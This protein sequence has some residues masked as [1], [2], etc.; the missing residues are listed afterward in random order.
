MKEPQG[1]P[2][3]LFVCAD[4]ELSIAEDFAQFGTDIAQLR[5]RLRAAQGRGRRRRSRSSRLSSGAGSAIENE[6][7][8]E[9]FHQTVSMKSVGNLTDFVRAH[10]LE[11]LD[12]AP[13]IEKLI[14]HFNDLNRAHEAVLKAK[15]A[16]R[17]VDAAG[18]RLR[19]AQRAF[20][21]SSS[22]CVLVARP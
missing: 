16:G 12:V 19:P 22:R 9:L 4:R 15:K 2:E 1:Q 14:E 21:P 6:Q 11:A 5:K 8:L 7:A 20:R 18:G 3:R 13:R 10:M 17:A